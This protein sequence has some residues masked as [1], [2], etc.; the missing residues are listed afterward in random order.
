ML[1]LANIACTSELKAANVDLTC[2]GC[3]LKTNVTVGLDMDVT[4]SDDCLD[5]S[6]G[7]CVTFNAM[8]MNLTVEEFEQ[9]IDLEVFIG[10][11]ISKSAEYK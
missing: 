2:V 11:T 4:L 7:S 9:V 3:V 10:S 1:A 5:S 6:D 8:A